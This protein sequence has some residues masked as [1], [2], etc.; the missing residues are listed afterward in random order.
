[1]ASGASGEVERVRRAAASLSP[2]ERDVLALAAGLGL[3]NAEVAARLG[4]G[5]QRA[6]RIL[7]RA[8][9]RFGGAL[10]GPRKPWWHL[11]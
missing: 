11:W 5:E 9:L 4:I 1:M 7:A 6:E 10:E 3:S 8:I 2:L